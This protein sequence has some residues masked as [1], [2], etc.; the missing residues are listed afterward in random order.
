MKTRSK[1]TYRLDG[2]K[3]AVASRRY[4]L[5]SRP[6]NFIKNHC[7]RQPSEV[8]QT[9]FRAMKDTDFR[10]SIE[11]QMMPGT[12]ADVYLVECDGDAW[13][14]KFYM[15]ADS[16]CPVCVVLSCNFDGFIH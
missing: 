12:M 1:P 7:E 3:Q 2:V 6:A 13:Y 14:V 16:A 5:K 11:L 9:V 10:K 8:V 4:R 15:D